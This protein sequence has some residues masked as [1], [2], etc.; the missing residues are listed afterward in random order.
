M[1][2][3]KGPLLH[4]LE[5]EGRWPILNDLLYGSG[6]SGG[7]HI[8]PRAEA[9]PVDWAGV[10]GREAPRTLEIGFN[11]G[12]F[13]R[14]LA[15]RF[16]ERDHVGIEIRR[17]YA[18]RVANEMGQSGGPRN[19]RVVWGDAK[20]VAPA[21]FPDGTVSEIH[22]N[23]PDPWWKKKHAKRRL[24][25]DDFSTM[26]ARLLAPGGSIWVKSDVPAI[27]EEISDALATCQGLVGPT[28]FGEADL[29][30][31]YRERKCLATGLPVTR[32]RYTRP[33]EGGA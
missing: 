13:L 19:V 21:I 31:S 10:F 29:P 28:A 16:P 18:W 2:R 14:E 22:I 26:L 5:G 6:D 1:P 11:R 3:L 15:E 17:R 20:I 23:F 27:A 4:P 30:L 12:W 33:V 9:L 8:V 24:V 25:D 7:H 32:F